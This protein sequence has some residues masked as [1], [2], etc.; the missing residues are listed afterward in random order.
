MIIDTHSHL[1]FQA[2]DADRG[3]VI[4][5]NQQA[6]VICIDVGTKYETSKNAVE[7]AE[8]NIYICP[9]IWCPKSMVSMTDEQ[10]NENNKK[11]PFEGEEPI[12]LKNSYWKDDS[13]RY[14]GVLDPYTHPKDFCLPCCFKHNITRGKKRENLDI[15]KKRKP[16]LIYISDEK[17]KAKQIEKKAK[18]DKVAEVAE[19]V[20]AVEAVEIIKQYENEDEAIIGNPKYIKGEFNWPLHAGHYGLLPTELTNIL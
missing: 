13:K 14:I 9:K 15:C 10:F 18:I 2:Y 3:E 20:Q 16:D 7:L 19:E 1:N 6:G 5:R 17:E 11:C 8:K 12:H 4:K